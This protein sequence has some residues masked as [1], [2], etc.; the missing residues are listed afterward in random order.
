MDRIMGRW[1]KAGVLMLVAAVVFAAC[2]GAAG[3]SG[4][5]GPQGPAGQD[6]SQGPPGPAGEPG[7]Q[8]PPGPAGEPGEQ[9]PPGPGADAGPTVT[10]WIGTKS[11]NEKSATEA[12]PEITFN[13]NDYFSGAGLSFEILSVS[14]PYYADGDA[15]AQGDQWVPRAGPCDGCEMIPTVK[16]I[17]VADDGMV[18]IGIESTAQ[19]APSAVVLEATDSNGASVQQ[20]FYVRRNKAPTAVDSNAPT[21]PEVVDDLAVHIGEVSMT[22]KLVKLSELFTDDDDVMVTERFNS[23]EEVATIAIDNLLQTSLVSAGKPGISEITLRGTDTGDLSAVK[24]VDVFVYE[25]PKLKGTL[26][27]KITFSLAEAQ[28]DSDGS[29]DPILLS[30]FVTEATTGPA[31]Q[32]GAE[33]GAPITAVYGA[34]KSSNPAVATLAA[35]ATGSFAVTIK[36]IGETEITVD[37][38]Q[39]TGPGIDTDTTG[40]RF[41]QKVTAKFIIEVT[42]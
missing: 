12:G 41:E 36:S 4:A 18:T 15:V 1:L 19:Y 5:V 38:T 10:M 30:D 33:A 29:V 40:N 31:G 16:S 39:I 35:G 26:P 37:V 25:G 20:T 32:T 34:P 11:S 27:A 8:G 23:N 6:G 17:S 9:G 28:G 7:S 14:H 22:S 3:V 21:T 42:R 13:A 24:V 2:E